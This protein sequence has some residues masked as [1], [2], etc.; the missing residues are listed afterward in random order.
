M[1]AHPEKFLG[2]RV[3]IVGGGY[4]A[5]TAIGHVS[6]LVDAQNDN[7]DEI[8]DRGAEDSGRKLRRNV[9]L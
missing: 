5:I 3:L 1:K 9:M 7:E 8:V 6:A 2:K 4:S